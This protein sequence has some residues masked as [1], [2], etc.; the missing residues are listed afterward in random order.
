MAKIQISANK[1]SEYA[2][3]SEKAGSRIIKDLLRQAQHGYLHRQCEAAIVKHLV[4]P[5]GDIAHLQ[6]VEAQLDAAALRIEMALM[7]ETDAKKIRSLKAK[8]NWPA[9][10]RDVIQYFL[11]LQPRVTR[12][13]LPMKRPPPDYEKLEV[14]RVRIT[15]QPSALIVD[16]EGV[17]AGAVKLYLPKSTS[18]VEE[19]AELLGALITGGLEANFGTNGSEGYTVHVIDVP[20]QKAF[21]VT[22]PYREI[23]GEVAKIAAEVHATWKTC[24]AELAAQPTP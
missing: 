24:L 22:K 17:V 1:F 6:E 5:G 9:T 15:V 3:A 23:R 11:K 16:D 7:S 21:M 19:R 18:L 13:N 10:N 20:S 4:S 8:L 14:G 12:I 2:F